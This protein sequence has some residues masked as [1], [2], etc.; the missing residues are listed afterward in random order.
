MDD[1]LIVLLW[2]ALDDLLERATLQG[3]HQDQIRTIFTR[4]DATLSWNKR[5]TR[6]NNKSKRVVKKKEVPRL[7]YSDDE[8]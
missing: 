2:H 5:T 1:V 6:K 8:D 4:V 7:T 3:I